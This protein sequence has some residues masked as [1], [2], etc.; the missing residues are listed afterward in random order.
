MVI[1]EGSQIIALFL[2]IGAIQT[3]FLACKIPLKWSSKW[4]HTWLSALLITLA[5]I[6]LDSVL[7]ETGYVLVIPHWANVSGP[8]LFLPGPLFYLYVRQLTNLHQ[9]KPVSKGWHFLP[10]LLR[11]FTYFPFYLENNL[12]KQR[13]LRGSMV[14]YP[15]EWQFDN[16]SALTITLLYLLATFRLVYKT[17]PIRINRLSDW[18]IGKAGTSYRLQIQWLW[19]WWVVLS[20][21]WL[22]W[23]Y[24]QFRYEAHEIA[25]IAVMFSLL[26]YG[27]AY[28]CFQFQV[29]TF[30]QEFTSDTHSLQRFSTSPP[31]QYQTSGLT[32]IEQHELAKRLINL[33][34]SEQLYR[35][36]DLS[37]DEL[38]RRLAITPHHLSQL[39]NQTLKIT[40]YELLNQYRVAD[41]KK[42]LQDPNQQ[43]FTLLALAMDAGFNSKATFN[44]AFKRHTGFTPSAFRRI[45]GTASKKDD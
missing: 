8:V 44:A 18:R 31:S 22:F 20:I 7:H 14:V 41:V 39:L 23:G 45:T 10:A 1:R 34:Q 26:M 5:F 11:L 13:Y 2:T 3:L 37:L 35:Q 27:M 24:S 29:S 19:S 38:A 15:T 6:I 4:P 9:A 43:R 21:C 16:Y 12:H 30:S 36:P 42:A 40:F 33:M 25:F 32:A 28:R 17:T